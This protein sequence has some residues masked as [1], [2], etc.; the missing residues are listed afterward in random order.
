MN[1]QKSINVA[2]KSIADNVMSAIEAVEGRLQSSHTSPTCIVVRVNGYN[3]IIMIMS[4][5]ITTYVVD[6]CIQAY[7]QW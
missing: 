6:L 7:R 5:I 4:P 1:T 2:T 3:I